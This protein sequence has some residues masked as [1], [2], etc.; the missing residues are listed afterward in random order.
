MFANNLYKYKYYQLHNSSCS[1][2]C[3]EEDVI[4]VRTAPIMGKH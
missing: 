3:D 1:S 2:S 4:P